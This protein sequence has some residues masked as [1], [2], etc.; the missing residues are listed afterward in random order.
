M[1]TVA[2]LVQALSRLPQGYEVVALDHSLSAYGAFVNIT[3]NDDD[4][5]VEVRTE[6]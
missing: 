3:V 4:R 5:R 6:L 2:Q 1:I